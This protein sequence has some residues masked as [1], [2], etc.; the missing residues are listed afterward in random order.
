[1]AQDEASL[2]AQ[3]V[4]GEFVRTL[5]VEERGGDVYVGRSE[6]R[7]W[8]RIFGGLVLAQAAIAAGRTVDGRTL[9][10]MHAYFVRGGK[11]D[12]PIEYHVERVRD[13]RT[14]TAR[15][16]LVRQGAE[17][18]CDVTASYV[19][20]EEGIS[21]FEPMGEVPPPESLPDF[22]DPFEPDEDPT[23]WPFELKL[24]MQ[25]GEAAPAAEADG[26]W[27]RVRAPLPEDPTIHTAALVWDSDAG[28]FAG[29]ER[30]YG[31]DSIDFHAS[32]S[33]DHAI[34]IHRPVRWD[35]WIFTRT[36]TP[37]AHAGRALT[38]RKMYRRD[39][40]HFATMAQEAIARR[41]GS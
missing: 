41:K 25:P 28:S 26:A 3:R 4:V 17:A 15:R 13:G 23:D 12:L 39:G 37:V 29:I 1:M 6:P 27:V 22:R 14:F 11:P 2:K 5:A 9:H 18:I 32:A 8:G 35:D 7:E 19:R 34:W 31:W 10:S 38:L 33:L 24:L 21:H 30:R 40:T 16:V 36:D 20:P